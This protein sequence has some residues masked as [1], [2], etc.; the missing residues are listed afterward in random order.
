LKKVIVTTTIS[1][2]SEAVRRFDALPDWTLVVATD[3]KTPI[4]YSLDRGVVVTPAM[5]NDYDKELSELIG[6]DCIQ[7]R[8]FAFLWAMEL[9]ADLVAVVDDDVVPTADWGREIFVGHDL[10]LDV[11]DPSPA[12]VFDP[13]GVTNHP[14][15][16]HRG[17][18]L[19]LVGTR[20]YAHKERRKM[21]VEIQ[22][23]FW[24][25]AG[26][27]D[28]VCRMLFPG[29][30]AFEPARFPFT[31]RAVAPF[32][33]MNV[34]LR[35]ALLRDYFLFPHV[36]RL[37]DV[38]ASYYLQSLGPRVVF[39]APTVV[40]ERSPRD[41]TREMRLEMDGYLKT[42]DLVRDLAADPARIARYIPERSLQ[43]FECYRSHFTA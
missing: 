37:D 24:D 33:A 13:V 27:F 7:R 21:R 15:R 2:P 35:P 23:S 18:P 38:W 14:E 41:L 20:S 17:F 43:A 32:S 6:W 4:G 40:H 3:R 9:G 25:G 11:Y 5:Q 29:A 30:V 28:A 42:L 39:S 10:E 34:F 12:D 31:S 19:Q 22:E 16:W 1:E 36:G 26:D 8:N